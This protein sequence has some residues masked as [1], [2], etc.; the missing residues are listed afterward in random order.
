ME[1]VYLTYF[2]LVAF[3]QQLWVCGLLLL[4]TFAVSFKPI[5]DTMRH[6]YDYGV[7]YWLISQTEATKH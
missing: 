5:V 2:C 3:I 1:K 6:L 7:N 4:S